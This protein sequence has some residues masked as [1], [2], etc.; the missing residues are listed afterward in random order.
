MNILIVGDSWGSGVWS[1]RPDR[2]GKVVHPGITFFLQ[3]LG[4][5]VTNVSRSG[6]AHSQLYNFLIK[7]D[8]KK[9]DYILVFHS[10]PI[11]EL[12]KG[13]KLYY[14]FFD[15]LPK[16]SVTIDRLE[17]IYHILVTDFYQ[18]LNS[19]GTKIHLLGGHNKIDPVIKDYP[20]LIDFIPSMREHFYPNFTERLINY[21]SPPTFENPLFQSFLPKLTLESLDF[22]IDNKNYWDELLVSQ[23]EYFY[24]DGYHLNISG[25]SKLSEYLIKNLFTNK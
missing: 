15:D 17:E 18:N 14:R 8:L 3:Q 7:T 6:S 13:K 23:K 20:N 1:A 10:N 21:A 5:N 9:F 24:P 19:L 22:V 11:R 12:F 25:H 4:L 16:C 2:M